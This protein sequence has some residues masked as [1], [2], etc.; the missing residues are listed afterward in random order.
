MNGRMFLRSGL[1]RPASEQNRSGSEKCTPPTAAN[2]ALGGDERNPRA[3]GGR[4]DRR[5]KCKAN[6]HILSKFRQNFA[7]FRLYRHRFLQEHLRFAAFFKIYQIITLKFSKLI[8]AKF[9]KF[10]D[11]MICKIFAEFSQK[12]LIFQTDSLRNF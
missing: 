7:R 12:L 6:C 3:V 8:L 11:I 10:Y 4:V 5:V 1:E 2:R 9:C